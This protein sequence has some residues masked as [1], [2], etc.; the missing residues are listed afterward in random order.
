MKKM[1]YIYVMEHYSA[2]NE[3]MPFAATWMDLEIIELSE[4]R[5]RQILYAVTCMQNLKLDTTEPIYE[6]DP[7]TQRTDL[8]CQGGGGWER[9]DGVEVRAQQMQASIYRVAQGTQYPVI[10][11]YEKEC[12]YMYVCVYITE[13]VYCTAEINTIL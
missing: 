8:G 7:Q 13:S 4:V 5:Q 6:T 10:N 11:H 9:G 12:V 3:T 1:W 2:K